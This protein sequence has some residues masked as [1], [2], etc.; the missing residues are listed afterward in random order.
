M[1]MKYNNELE[2]I[3]DEKKAYFLGFIYADGC[4][5]ITQRGNNKGV[6]HVFQMSLVDESI[7]RKLQSV[8]P[9]LNINEF[10]YGKYIATHRRQFALRKV[11]KKLF[12][13]L[14]NNGVFE[15][16]SGENANKLSLPNIK[17][18]LLNHFV[19]G[20]FD[21][22][23]SISIPKKRPNM[24]RADMCGT[25]DNLIREIKLLLEKNKIKCPIYRIRTDN[26]VAPLSVLEWVNYKDI[27]DLK[28]YLYKDATIF[29]DRKKELFDSFNLVDKKL[30]NPICPLC[31]KHS[32]MKAGSRQ[33]KKGL[34]LRFY[35]LSCKKRFT[36]IAQTKSDKLLENPEEDNQQPII[37]LK[38]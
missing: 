37:S 10:D 18:S 22:D 21:G 4:I 20:Y 33:M 31:G 12:M 3:D 8:F 19:R 36:I 14:L 17:G 13:D 26:R 11:S 30:H 6:K 23:G 29:L 16:K 27:T 7:V 1:T 28:E 5:S 34:A 24:R 32:V 9:F 2:V 38:D 15:R 25:C 35:C